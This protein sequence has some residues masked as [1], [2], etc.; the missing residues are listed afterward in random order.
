MANL[1]K[2]RKRHE[3]AK[4]LRTQWALSNGEFSRIDYEGIKKTFP[5]KQ[6]RDAYVNAVIEGL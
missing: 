2:T 3:Q 5:N 4:E 1:N 6:D